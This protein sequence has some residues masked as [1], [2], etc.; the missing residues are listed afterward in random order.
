MLEG[1]PDIN[2]QFADAYERHA[3]AIFRNCHLQLGNRERAL[4]MAQE[5]FLRVWEYIKSGK[6][7]RNFKTFLYRVSDNLVIDE[8]RRSKLREVVSLE[9]M[10]EQG[11]D[12]G[13]EQL[14]EVQ[15][16]LDVWRIL[17]RY[18]NKSS[19][20][21]KLLR[22]RYILGMP[23]SAIAKIVGLPSNT[24]AVKLHRAVRSLEKAAS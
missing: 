14:D 13:E 3:D 5:T 15:R 10:Q 17:L 19:E 24:I 23:P 2:R 20:D 8:I 9:D 1:I 16:K 12:P 6:E 21:Y 4:E 7:V 22:M 18:K 11:F